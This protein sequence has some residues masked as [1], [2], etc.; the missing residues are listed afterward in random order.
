MPTDP[1]HPPIL[2]V[3]VAPDNAGLDALR[4]AGETLDEFSV[5]WE[6]V[7]FPPC[8]PFSRLEPGRRVVIAASGDATLPAALAERTGLPVIRVPVADGVHGGLALVYDEDGNLPSGQRAGEAFATV[9]I[10]AA[11]AKNAALFAV[12]TLALTDPRLRAQ[13]HAFRAR[14]TETVLAHPPLNLED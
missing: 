9:A 3:L 5:G 13:W 8:G 6:P 7:L 1:S 11:G 12:A 14:Q 2:V 4:P 10:G